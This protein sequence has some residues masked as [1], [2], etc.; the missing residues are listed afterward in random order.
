M[1]NMNIP[2]FTAAA[3]LYQAKERYQMTETLV[4]PADGSR[5]LPQ[6]VICSGGCCCTSFGCFCQGG[7]HGPL[8][9]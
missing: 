4:A 7:G 2:G 3:S 6:W 1:N 5:V 8:K 9:M